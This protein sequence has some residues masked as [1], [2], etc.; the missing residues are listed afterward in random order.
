MKRTF[1][2]SWQSTSDREVNS[3][4]IRRALEAAEIKLSSRYE[5]D[6]AAR[7]NPGSPIIFDVIKG[8]IDSCQVFV[9]DLSLVIASE[10]K[11]SSNPNVLIEY[12]YALAKL[13]HLRIIL[14]VNR[15]FGP[16]ESLPFDIRHSEVVCYNLAPE[17]DA[18]VRLDTEQALSRELL[19]KLR[20]TVE[21]P[22]SI[23]SLSS[24]E[25]AV[26]THLVRSSKRG[27]RGETFEIEGIAK[28]V[29]IPHSEVNEAAAD[30]VSRGYVERLPILG[31]TAPPISPTNRLFWDMDIFVHEWDPR[32]D[33]RTIAEALV[34]S[35]SSGFGHLSIKP[36]CEKKKWTWRQVNPALTFL[37]PCAEVS[38]NRDPDVYT[39][40]VRENELTRRFLSGAWNPDEH[41]RG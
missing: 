6:D 8:K 18:S 12:G 40:Q 14:V 35:G 21:D 4:L 15:H 29:N 22:R 38:G 24:T 30:L 3:D 33:A 1:F 26:A 10:V 20:S 27:I 39:V 32:V 28:E 9:A 11:P 19:T 37:E 36:F 7:G 17:A 34:Q 31:T 23:L 25:S 5:I 2:Y 41:R 13:G 16:P